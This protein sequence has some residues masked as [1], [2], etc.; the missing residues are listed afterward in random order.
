MT[1]YK[2]SLATTAL[3]TSNFAAAEKFDGTGPSGS[4]A[5]ASTRIAESDFTDVDIASGASKTFYVTLD[6]S[7]AASTKSLSIRIPA[8]TASS[9]LGFLWTDGVSTSLTAMGAD[10]PLLY[11]TFTY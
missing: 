11:K 6:T 8:G 10:L 7:D 5:A 9:N 3:A 1:V 2:D 4:V